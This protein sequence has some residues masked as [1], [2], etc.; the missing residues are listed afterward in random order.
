[1][2][3]NMDKSIYI[4]HVVGF[5]YYIVGLYKAYKLKILKAKKKMT[6]ALRYVVYGRFFSSKALRYNLSKNNLKDGN[7][8]YSTFFLCNL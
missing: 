3:S 2:I 7:V 4:A 8:I 5:I 6:K 1:M